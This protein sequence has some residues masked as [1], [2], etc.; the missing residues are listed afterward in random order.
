VFILLALAVYLSTAA[1]LALAFVGLVGVMHS[2]RK[3]NEHSGKEKNGT[4][5]IPMSCLCAIEF[6]SEKWLFNEFR[7]DLL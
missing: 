5:N 3:E 2:E 1:L 4:M 6:H 7:H